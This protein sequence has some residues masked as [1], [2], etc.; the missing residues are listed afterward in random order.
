MIRWE[1]FEEALSEQICLKWAGC[2]RIFS[3]DE[4]GPFKG[5]VRAKSLEAG[6]AVL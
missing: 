6:R 2:F 3:H 4:K 1:L 5:S